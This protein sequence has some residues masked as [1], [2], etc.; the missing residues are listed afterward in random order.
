[1]SNGEIGKIWN[2]PLDKPDEVN[3]KHTTF[4]VDVL[5]FFPRLKEHTIAWYCFKQEKWLFLCNQQYKKNE[6]FYWRYLLDKWD[7]PEV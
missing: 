7:K 1:M 3:T 2:S 6:K 5:C 4:T